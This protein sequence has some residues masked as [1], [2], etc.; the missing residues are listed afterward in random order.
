MFQTEDGE[1]GGNQRGIIPPYMGA[2]PVWRGR[3]S[4]RWGLRDDGTLDGRHPRLDGAT[5]ARELKRPHNEKLTRQ[6][7][8]T[9]GRKRLPPWAEINLIP[10][11]NGSAR[12]YRTKDSRAR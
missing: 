2:S 12:R 7:L 8:R 6:P 1:S 5:G 9:L 3:Y 11:G 10:P 4:K